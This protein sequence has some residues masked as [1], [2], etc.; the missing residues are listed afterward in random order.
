MATLQ[1]AIAKLKVQG[2]ATPPDIGTIQQ[3]T[4]L[5][6]DEKM[7]LLQAARTGNLN[8]LWGPVGGGNSTGNSQIPA[9]ARQIPAAAL[10]QRDTQL[11]VPL[12]G[13]AAAERDFGTGRRSTEVET[14]KP[15]LT[16]DDFGAGQVKHGQELSERAAQPYIDSY[17]W[18]E[19]LGLQNLGGQ[20]VQDRTG[21]EPSSIPPVGTPLPVTPPAVPDS[22]RESQIPTAPTPGQVDHPYDP[23]KQHAPSTGGGGLLG[24]IWDKITNPQIDRSGSSSGIPELPEMP[25]LIDLVPPDYSGLDMPGPIDFEFVNRDF[26]DEGKKL[27]SEAWEPQYEA[28]EKA[29][30]NSRSNY[31]T[32]DIVMQEMYSRLNDELETQ[33]Q[34]D[35]DRY[36]AAEA[37]RNKGA[38]TNQ[39]QLGEAYDSGD[40]IMKQLLAGQG[41]LSKNPEAQ[42]ILAQ[43]AAQEAGNKAVAQKDD[44]RRLQSVQ[45]RGQSKADYDSSIIKA[46]GIAGTVSREGLA[47]QLNNQLFEF[48]QQGLGFESEERQAALQLADKLFGRDQDFQNR[49]Y[50][51]L[52]ADQ[53]NAWNQYNAGVNQINQGNSVANQNTANQNAAN[54]TEYGT[55]V[56]NYW[57]QV[58]MDYKIT[59]DKMAQ[60]M[61][62]AKARAEA[63]GTGTSGS[64]DNLGPMGVIKQQIINDSPGAEPASVENAFQL[65]MKAYGEVASPTSN[66]GGR[67]KSLNEFVYSLLT[68]NQGQ[69]PQEVLRAAA[70]A[71]W[72]G[73]NEINAVPQPK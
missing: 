24:D 68:A 8:T 56:D 43:M 61:A 65:A 18:W 6:A 2:F 29:K 37:S 63:G 69:V 3:L 45:D 49:E 62:V 72:A 25:D 19:N 17:K 46:N 34:G 16:L 42:K 31:D 11:S 66:G 59:Q 10:Q 27:A 39:E 26:T 57:K 40:A 7:A 54:Q 53:A 70:M 41:N 30:K 48:D 67:Y 14:R 33:K 60:E 13:P 23:R 64:V 38:A 22:T 36:A 50:G 15:G 32:S 1:D 21:L 12:G 51:Q 52:T 4:G 73:M 5:G 55:E 47:R 28:L 9:A 71:V 44:A 58:E 35:I 20:L